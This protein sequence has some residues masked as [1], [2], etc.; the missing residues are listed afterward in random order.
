MTSYA[1]APRRSLRAAALVVVLLACAALG[2]WR[3]AAT[4]A[5]ARAAQPDPTA[6]TVG[7]VSFHITHVEQVR[8]LADADL[9]G[10]AHGVQSLVTDDKAL[11][12]VSLVVRAGSSAAA[13]DAG[14]LRAV[15]L[16]A[17]G[18][19]FAPVGGTLSPG[20][21]RAHAGIEGSLSFVV[22]RN[23]ARLAL[24]DPAGAHLLPLL[25]VDRF[26]A[27][28]HASGHQHSSTGTPGDNS[29]AP[30]PAGRPAP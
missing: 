16:P 12:N 10:M 6:I 2:C 30:T 26:H 8:G 11:I 15:S 23:G 19:V 1:P 21:L 20:R 14:T 29:P 4:V 24:R 17:P 9:G 27:P 5:E 13:Y 28:A 25:L 3:I 18:A 22:P 7:G